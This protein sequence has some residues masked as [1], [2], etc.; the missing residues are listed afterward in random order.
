MPITL[1]HT[2]VP[3]RDHDQLA[4]FFA[5]IFGLRYDG[6]GP[7]FAPVRVNESLVLDF[8]TVDSSET[9]HYAFHV[10][11]REFDEILQRIKEA[12]IAY[13]SSYRSP[14]DRQLNSQKEAVACISGI[15]AVIPSSS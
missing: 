12:G 7:H 15:P 8:D 5:S 10:S 2:I 1:D 11:D 3:S 6:L 4:R 13:G 14:E 9:H